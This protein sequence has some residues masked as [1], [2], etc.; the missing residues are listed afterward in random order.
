MVGDSNALP[1]ASHNLGVLKRDDLVGVEPKFRKYLVGLFAELRRR[2][3]ILLGVRN[4]M[5]G[6]PTSRM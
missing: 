5:T 6:W 4:S 3:T 1:L 2:A